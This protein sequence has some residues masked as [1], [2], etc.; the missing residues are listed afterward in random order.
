MRTESVTQYRERPTN[1]ALQEN[2]TN[3]FTQ[4]NDVGRNTGPKVERNFMRGHPKG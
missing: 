4:I 3:A 2:Q 1:T